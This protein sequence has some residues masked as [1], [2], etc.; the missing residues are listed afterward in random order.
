VFRKGGGEAAAQDM[1]V[2][3]L[4][5]IPLDPDVVIQ[6]DTGEPFAM[7][8]SDSATAACYHDIANKVEAFCKKS[9]SLMKIAPRQAH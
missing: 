6:S 7:F 1:G 3:F 2:P 5:R 8:N 9:G 4:G